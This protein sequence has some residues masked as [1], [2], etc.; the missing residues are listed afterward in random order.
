[1]SYV[2]SLKEVDAHWGFTDRFSEEDRDALLSATIGDEFKIN[3][4]SAKLDQRGNMNLFFDSN[5][6]R[7]HHEVDYE[8]L[9]Q[10][11]LNPDTV[12]LYTSY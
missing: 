7:R 1:M 2:V 5:A 10:Q 6:G 11:L 4:G 9:R 12:K 8:E 3:G